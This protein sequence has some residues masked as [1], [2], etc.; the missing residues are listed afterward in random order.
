MRLLDAIIQVLDEAHAPLHIQEI[1]EKLLSGGLWKTSGKTPADTVSA[2]LYTHIKQNG[3]HSPFIKVA[4]QTFMLRDKKEND[5]TPVAAPAD[6]EKT[7]KRQTGSSGLSFTDCAQKVLEAFGNK[8]PMHYREITQRAL[9]NGWLVTNGKTP[10][11]SMYAQIITE[12]KRQQ[13]RGEQ[14]CFIQLGRGEVALSQWNE[15][16]LTFQI[17]QHN[18][19]IRKALRE[20]LTAMSAGEFEEL[21]S[22]L[23]AEMGFEDVEVT[24]RSHDGGIDVRGTLIVADSIHIKMAVQAKK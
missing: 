22:I 6:T 5:N 4:P 1:T 13:S 3:I 10:E 9:D 16:G 15:H 2:R 14:P 17:E 21:I 11:A 23:L 8:K 20:K 19:R 12:I 7:C 18:A 24:K